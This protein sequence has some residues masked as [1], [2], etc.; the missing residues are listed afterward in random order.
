V[1]HVAHGTDRAWPEEFAD[2][3][4]R[5][6]KKDIYVISTPK[7]P[8][9][10]EHFLYAGKEL[11]KIVDTRGQFLGSGVRAATEALRRKQDKEREAAGLAP[12]GRGG[13]AGGRGGAG[14]GGPQGAGRGAPRGARGGARGGAP[15]LRGRGGG[16]SAAGG[17][18]RPGFGGDKS[19]WINLVNLLRKR[20]LLPVV[21]FVFSKRRC[22]EY[23]SSMPNTDLCNARE[24]SEVHILI[25]KSLTRL[26]GERRNALHH[27]NLL[28]NIAQAR[29]RACRRLRAC[30]SCSHAA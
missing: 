29:T 21:V 11:H 7:R 9:P 13:A 10:L 4:G 6:K 2:W 25:E 15:A 28:I 3:V 18:S 22:E 26:K 24:K 17:N 5:T 1:R 20:D 14:R 12:I 27:R 19:L 8:V 23:A 30:A 16:G